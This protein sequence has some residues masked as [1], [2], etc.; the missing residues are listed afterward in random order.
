MPTKVE[1]PSA[2]M[3][4]KKDG[5]VE[6]QSAVDFAKFKLYELC[7]QALYDSGKYVRTQTI[8]EI[9]RLPGMSRHRRPYKGVKFKMARFEDGMKVGLT[10]D[11]WYSARQELG[12][13]GMRKKGLLRNTTFN[14]AGVIEQIMRQYLPEMNSDSNFEAKEPEED[15]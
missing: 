7:R 14:S 15:D 2:K 9:K 11:A 5:K 4:I 13:S 6:F 3:K 10:H 12:D 1:R 8:K